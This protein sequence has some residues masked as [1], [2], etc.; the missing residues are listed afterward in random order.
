MCF[1]VVFALE[2]TTYNFER[3]VY[4]VCGVVSRRGCF[5]G[6]M[7]TYSM[8]FFVFFVVNTLDVFVATLSSATLL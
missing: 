2:S 4:M 3:C 6:V 1:A 7:T 5:V 8:P